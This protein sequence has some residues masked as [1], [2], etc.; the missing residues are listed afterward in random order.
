MKTVFVENSMYKC[1]MFN[2]YYSFEKSWFD[3]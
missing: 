1:C 3:N 2:I